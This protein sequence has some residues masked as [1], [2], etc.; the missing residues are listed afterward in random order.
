VSFALSLGPVV[1][2]LLVTTRL[3]AAFFI[4]PP[5]NGAMVPIRV[6]LALAGAIA[7]VV[8]DQQSIDIELETLALLGA[9]TYQV[10]VGAAFGYLVNLMLSAA[11]IAGSMVDNLAGFSAAT[12]FDPFS[13]SS[14][15]PAARINQVIALVILVLIEGHLLIVRGILRS[16]S[17][18]PID[19]LRVDAMGAMLTRG[20]GQLMIA[21]IEIALPVLAALL[22]AE[23]VLALAARAAPR[24]NVMVVGFAV[25]SMI[26]LATF[27]LMVPLVINSVSTLLVRSLRWAMTTTGA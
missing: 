3:L 26:L 6:R 23:V 10:V 5:F 16:F 21:A 13:Q 20:V 18:A 1:T 2:F 8:S 25:K 9:V 12:L 14:S 4:A 7:L 11:T 15:S 24:L 19:G 27:A 17:A 22:L